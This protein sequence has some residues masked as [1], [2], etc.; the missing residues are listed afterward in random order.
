[1]V[2]DSHIPVLWIGFLTH[3]VEIV[4]Q[5]SQERFAVEVCRF[6]MPRLNSLDL[7]FAHNVFYDLIENTPLK[8]FRCPLVFVP[9]SRHQTDVLCVLSVNKDSGKP[10]G[11]YCDSPLQVGQ[12]LW[13][14]YPS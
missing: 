14:Y 5:E 6:V 13:N 2:H 4:K 3:L 7:I 12:V 8:L 9:Y 1:M 11:L 10:D